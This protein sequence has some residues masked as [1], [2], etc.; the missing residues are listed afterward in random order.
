MNLYS[1]WRQVVSRRGAAWLA[2]ADAGTRLTR[3]TRQCPGKAVAA[4]H[5]PHPVVDGTRTPHIL[6]TVRMRIQMLWIW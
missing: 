1:G 6:P 3:S 2:I 5:A 4:G